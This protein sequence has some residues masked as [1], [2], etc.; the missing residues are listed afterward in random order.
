[1]PRWKEN[2]LRGISFWSPNFPDS[3]KTN[4][5]PSTGF[6]REKFFSFH[7]FRGAGVHWQV[8]ELQKYIQI[9]SGG[10]N[11]PFNT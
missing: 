7:I 8:S 11:D 5:L 4:F 3:R 1:M 9:T 10:Y 6:E 2:S